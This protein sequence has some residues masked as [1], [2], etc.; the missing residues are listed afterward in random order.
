MTHKSTQ[1]ATG[2]GF[3]KHGVLIIFDTL[4][5]IFQ[6]GIM[7]SNCSTLKSSAKYN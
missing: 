4:P 5:L 7:V 1:H 2:T 6:D 3:C